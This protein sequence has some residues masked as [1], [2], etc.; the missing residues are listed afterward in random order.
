MLGSYYPALHPNSVQNLFMLG[1]RE[2]AHA[3]ACQI[4]APAMEQRMGRNVWIRTRSVSHARIS[5]LCGCGSSVRQCFSFQLFCLFVGA[6][7]ERI[8]KCFWFF[9]FSLPLSSIPCVSHGCFWRAFCSYILARSC[10]NR[11]C[12]REKMPTQKSDTW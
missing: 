2:R 9:F 11:E 4:T 3:R 6:M 10:R 8:S 7:V 12:E 5:L 1:A